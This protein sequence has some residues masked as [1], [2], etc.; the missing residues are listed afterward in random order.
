MT[1]ATDIDT[2]TEVPHAYVFISF[3]TANDRTS[4]S[5]RD[6][7]PYIM[8]TTA[9]VWNQ[10]FAAGEID[11]GTALAQVANA[12]NVQVDG[13]S[14]DVN[15]SNQLRRMALTGDITASTGSGATTLASIVTGSSVGDSTH[16]P[17]LTYDNKGRIT[18]VSTATPTATAST[19][20]TFVT[21]MGF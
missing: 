10:F 7:G 18:A 8:G 17:V 4:W 21:A 11:P 16:I 20:R 13:T 19:Q 15:G 2:N 1:R 12:F 14:V 3:G 6:P 9:I 5:V